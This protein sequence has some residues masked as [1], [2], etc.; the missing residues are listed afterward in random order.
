MVNFAASMPTFDTMKEANMKLN[1]DIRKRIHLA[2]GIVISLLLA[3]T[4]IL[5]CTSCYSI[6]RSASVQMYTY[7][8]IG[9]AF[10]K[11]APMVY[12]TLLAILGGIVLSLVLPC[13]KKKPR[14][15]R[16]I[17]ATYEGLAERVQV[18]TASEPLRKQIEHERKLRRILGAVSIVLFVLEATLPLIYLLD[19]DNFLGTTSH[20]CTQEVLRCMLVYTACLLPLFLYE[21]VSLVLIERSLTRETAYLKAA[22]KEN[23]VSTSEIGKKTN[24]FS[25]IKHFFSA[26]DKTVVLCVRIAVIAAALVLIVAGIANGGML[27]VLKK[28]AEICAECIGLG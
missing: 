12:L 15:S 8:R 24:T 20:E 3:A 7:E 28:A 1:N 25:K 10:S 21:W 5:L 9:E 6:Y 2:A 18:S 16:S 27:D 11:I 22:I 17:R 23:G 14:A 4:G 19:P 13:E 26:H